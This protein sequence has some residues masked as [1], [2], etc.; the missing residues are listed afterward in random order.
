MRFSQSVLALSYAVCMVPG[1]LLIGGCETGA[2]SEPAEGE[3]SAMHLQDSA[4]P[5]DPGGA[6]CEDFMGDAIDCPSG[7]I[8]GCCRQNPD[9]SGNYCSPWSGTPITCGGGS[10]NPGTPTCLSP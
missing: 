1:A 10:S 3:R 8:C 2:D 9:P 7:T 4:E 5:A 6:H